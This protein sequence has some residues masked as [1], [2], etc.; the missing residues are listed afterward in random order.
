[1]LGRR[2]VKY[3]SKK[4]KFS[5]DAADIYVEKVA[6]IAIQALPSKSHQSL[7]LSRAIFLAF[8]LDGLSEAEHRGAVK[9]GYVAGNAVG[10]AVALGATELGHGL[11]K[12]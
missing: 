7:E 1:M 2:K 4:V 12:L 6:R 3:F 10:R 5:V 11:F 8:C 9:I